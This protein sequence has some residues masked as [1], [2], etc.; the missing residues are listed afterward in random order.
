MEN[1]SSL[2][3]TPKGRGRNNVLDLVKVI[4]AV[5]VVFVH[6]P[7]S[8]PL[9]KMIATLGTS[10]VILFFMIS[11]YAAYKGEDIDNSPAIWRRIKRTGIT[12]LIAIVAYILFSIIICLATN[13]FDQ[14]LLL[15]GYPLFY[16]RMVFLGDFDA[17]GGD[18]LW[19]MVALFY[20]YFPFLLF[21]RF[22]LRK[23]ALA[24][25]PFLLIL[26][27]GMETYTNSVYAD[28]HWAGNALVG[29]LPAMLL[30]YWVHI[31]EEQLLKA[32]LWSLLCGLLI[33]TTLMFVTAN[34]WVYGLDVS[35]VFK[36]STALLGFLCCLKAKDA[37]PDNPISSFGAEG[38]LFVYLTHQ[39]IGVSLQMFVFADESFGSDFH[40]YAL[41][42]IVA[43]SAI[44]VAFIFSLIKRTGNSLLGKRKV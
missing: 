29:A 39:M 17:F 14:W 35:Q 31:K 19:F 2:S 1:E 11:G 16:L 9:G 13:T 40:G 3:A 23:L 24:L 4:I 42:W 25:L 27:I 18:A 8:G 38:T 44:V 12:A 33:S 21:E 15:W 36:I 20:A 37:L 30:G 41:P 5:G 26:K 32:S 6:F 43:L 34:V 22:K 7:M 28:W 10:G